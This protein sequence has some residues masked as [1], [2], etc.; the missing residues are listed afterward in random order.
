MDRQN[1][2]QYWR[3]KSI[4]YCKILY[5]KIKQNIIKKIENRKKKEKVEVRKILR[6]AI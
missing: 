6:D 1:S 5:W 4:L 2:Y 3:K